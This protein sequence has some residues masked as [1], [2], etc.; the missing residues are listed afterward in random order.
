LSAPLIAF[1][2]RIGDLH[3]DHAQNPRAGHL[4]RINW[5][6]GQ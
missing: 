2:P 3:D 6:E 1:D 4:R 5:S